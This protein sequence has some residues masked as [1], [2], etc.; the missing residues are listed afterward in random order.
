MASTARISGASVLLGALSLG[1]TSGEQTLST[2][3]MARFLQ[4]SKVIDSRPIGKGSTRPFRLT[5]SD[6]E[7]THD[8]AFQSIDERAP[9]KELEGGKVLR[10]VDSYHFNVAAFGLAEI[11]GL[12]NMV[13]VSIERTWNRKRGSLTWW[14]ENKWDENEWKAS[15]V[16]PPDI[17][18]WN[19][20]IQTV[21]V[22]AQ[23]VYDT[24]RN[25]GNVLITGDWRIWMIDFTRAFR[26][27]HELKSETGLERCEAALLQKLRSLTRE[28]IEEKVSPHL[29]RS[30]I[31]ALLAR[32]DLLVEHYDALI[33]ERGA[34]RVL[35]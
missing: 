28:A 1:A 10:F 35:Y 8:A 5:L 34:E 22:F 12:E 16:S 6:G 13:P 33:R 21:R 18:A 3:E 25:R 9:V 14:V 15:G 24:D 2:Q 7:R 31:D 27:W 17:D 23:L 11:L 32:R 30:E 26:P 4:T 29:S 20:Q 19:G